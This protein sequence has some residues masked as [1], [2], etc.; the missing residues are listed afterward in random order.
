MSRPMLHP[1]FQHTFA[2]VA[3]E[4]VYVESKLTQSL[5]PLAPCEAG[6]A[7]GTLG[8]KHLGIVLPT[9]ELAKL[10]IARL[11]EGFMADAA[12]EALFMQGELPHLHHDLPLHP[13]AALRAVCHPSNPSVVVRASARLR[14]PVVSLGRRWMLG[15]QLCRRCGRWRSTRRRQQPAQAWSQVCHNLSF[16]SNQN[17]DLHLKDLVCTACSE[18]QT[19]PYLQT[20]INNKDFQRQ[21]DTPPCSN[22]CVSC[23]FC[24]RC[25]ELY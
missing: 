17:H 8:S 1:G 25:S 5:H 16:H 22:C 12:G 6:V 13:E 14:L 20:T 2:H 18:P 4:A 11:F 3:L 24:V 23:M 9:V 21:R 15:S 7:P 10:G 19:F